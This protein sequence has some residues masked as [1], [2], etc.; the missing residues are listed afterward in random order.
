MYWHSTLK[1]KINNEIRESLS[2]HKSV[3]HGY[4]LTPHLFILVID[5]LGHMLKDPKVGVEGLTIPKIGMLRDQTFMDD[6]LTPN[7]LLV[8]LC[9]LG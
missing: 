4:P 8:N 1:I 2:L 5:I 6:G 7:E 3:R 9:Q